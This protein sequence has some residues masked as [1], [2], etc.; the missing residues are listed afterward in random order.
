MLTRKSLKAMG[1]TDEQ[2]DSIVE[3]HTETVD[4]LKDKIKSAEEKASKLDDVQKELDDLKAKSGEDF[5]EKYNKEHAD[6]EAYKKSVTEKETRAAKESAV[7]AYFEAKGITGTNL[8]IA[9]RGAKDEIGAV[10]LDGDKIKNTDA[11]DSLI[12]G[13]YK[14]LVVTTAVKGAPTATPP[15]NTGGKMTKADIFKKDD[16]GRYIMSTAERQKALAENPQL[17]N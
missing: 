10:E 14:G 16:H 11:L 3:M 13:E 12:N 6:F 7:K 17:L 4:G 15:A 2:V 5:K 1:L 8:A 9:M